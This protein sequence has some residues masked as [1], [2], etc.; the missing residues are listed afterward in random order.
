ML[1]RM[2]RALMFR[3][4]QLVMRGPLARFVILLA[5][6]LFVSLGGGILVHAI[7]SGFDSAG[8]AIWW[9]FLRLTDPGYLGD[10]EGLARATVSTA[11]TVLGY[12]L[13]MGALIAILVQWLNQTMN[14]LEQGLTPVALQ[15]HIVLLGWSSRSPAIVEEILISEG[16]VQRFLRQR[17]ARRLRVAVLAERA[18]ADLLAQLRKQMQERWHA[19]QIVLRSGSSLQLKGLERVDF[20][21]AAAVLIP[22]ADSGAGSALDADA[23]SVKTLMTMA[24]ALAEDPP[25][26][27]PLMIVELQEIRYAPALRALYPGPMEILAG[28]TIIVQLMVQALRQPGLSHVFEEFLSDMD[29]S[30]IYVREEPALIG[31]PIR[32][33]A[34]AFP[35]GVLLGLVRPDGQAFKALLNPPDDLRLGPGDRVAVLAPS[36]G[37]ALPPPELGPEVQFDERPPP[38][39]R[40]RAKRRVLVLGWNR[41]VPALVRELASH[42]E[43]CFDIDIVAETTVAKR[44]KRIAAEDLPEDR[45]RVRQLELDYTIPAYLEDLELGG[46]DNILL[47]QSEGLKAGAESDA[48]TTLGYLLVRQLVRGAAAPNVL[49]ELTDPDN[50][51]LFESRLENERTEILIT[52]R[53]VSH[54]LARVTLRRELRAVFD[55]LFGP[56]G[57]DIGFYP[58]GDYGLTPGA[59]A[60]T[61]LQKAADARGD[62]AIGVRRH[63]RRN[64]PDG[65][66]ELNPR[67]D[68]HLDL[69]E[70]DELIVISTHESTGVPSAATQAGAVRAEL[71]GDRSAAGAGRSDAVASCA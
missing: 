41:R 52:P 34:Y 57:C 2:R 16:R 4:E 33:L 58:I 60:F 11:V 25:E 65:G 14:R 62:I 9:A 56:G 26:E 55:T 59:Y 13:F 7:A 70:G 6:I 21:H 36:Y 28:D 19:R 53:I 22:A 24:A 66:V 10:D 42:A 27:P 43:E 23:R 1:A 68:Q 61:D 12:I 48:R 45:I 38:Q 40:T 31:H 49:M 46:Y 37:D 51:S 54:M 71:Q 30:Q 69:A 18:G 47:L 64:A 29:G 15:A 20:A 44:Q 5:L 3:L 67:R 32:Q 39:P 63:E 35:E 50:S 8:E 17:G